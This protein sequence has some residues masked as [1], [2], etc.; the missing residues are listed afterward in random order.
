M[1]RIG[2]EVGKIDV[3]GYGKSRPRDQ[4]HN[5]KAWERNRRV[6]FVLIRKRTVP[7]APGAGTPPGEPTPAPE[8]AP[9]PEPAPEKAPGGAP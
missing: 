4:R 7:A 9:A 3:K 5:E 2:V 1:I 8:A 6:E